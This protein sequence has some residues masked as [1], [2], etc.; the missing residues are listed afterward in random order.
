METRLS[1]LKLDLRGTMGKKKERRGGPRKPA[2]GC[3]PG[4]V[5]ERG[6][7]VRAKVATRGLRARV[8]RGELRFRPKGACSASPT[9]PVC[10][11]RL[12]RVR[13]ENRTGARRT[14]AHRAATASTPQPRRS[15]P[16][17]PAHPWRAA[18]P[19]TRPPARSPPP[20]AP[21]MPPP[22]TPSPC[23]PPWRRL[24]VPR[25]STPESPRQKAGAGGDPRR[26]ARRESARSG[27]PGKVGRRAGQRKCQWEMHRPPPPR[28]RAEAPAR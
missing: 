22:H 9:R 6:F 20:G 24:G 18:P 2:E 19:G 13:S 23:P 26:R 15:H 1:S 8:A 4:I 14:L 12:T 11:W 3:G 16:P 10:R 28:V 5:G 17:H 21:C 25:A 7:N 27:A